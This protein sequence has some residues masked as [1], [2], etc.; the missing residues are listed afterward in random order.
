MLHLN[1]PFDMFPWEE[2]DLELYG[3]LE[4]RSEASDPKD[5]LVTAFAE[6]KALGPSLKRCLDGATQYFPKSLP[7]ATHTHV[8][9]SI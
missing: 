1:Q 3:S 5:Y 9:M 8:F 4:A 2:H 6:A 7:S